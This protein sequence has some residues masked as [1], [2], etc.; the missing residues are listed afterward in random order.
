MAKEITNKVEYISVDKLE[1][2]EK[3]PRKISKSHLERLKRKLEKHGDLLE[4]RPLLVSD[5][6]GKLVVFGGN[7]RLKAARELGL[8]EVPCVVYRGLSYDDERE[9]MIIDNVEEGE[10]WDEVLEDE[11][12][13]LDLEDLG[14]EI[15][16]EADIIEVASAGSIEEYSEDTDYDTAKFYREKISDGIIEEI[17]NGM[18]GGAIREE[19]GEVMLCRVKQYTVFNF[20]ELIKY[21]RSDDAT[22]TERRLMRKLF[23]VFITPKEAVEEGILE[24]ST[25]TGN[26]Y[27][28]TEVK[29]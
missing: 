12:G 13:D 20:D 9:K 16:S 14:I 28:N 27:D 3:N 15:E 19:L 26:I 25:V 4:G 24:I 22:D 6:T 21:Y 7:Q 2:H 29:K 10:W 18:S 11:F 1:L 8:K 5:R 23:L 17:V